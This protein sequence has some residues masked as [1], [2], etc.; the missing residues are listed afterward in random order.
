MCIRDRYIIAD[1]KYGFAKLQETQDGM[2]MSKEWI[3]RRLDDAVGKEKADEI[4]DA[5]EEDPSSV[6]ALVYH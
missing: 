6:K 5:Y 2:Q 3:D 1:A 4:R